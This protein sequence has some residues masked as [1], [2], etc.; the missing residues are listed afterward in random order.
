MD[1]PGHHHLHQASSPLSLAFDATS[2]SPS[3]RP[4]LGATGGVFSIYLSTLLMADDILFQRDRLT[5]AKSHLT[6]GR[7][8]A[9]YS[10]ISAVSIYDGRPL[11]ASAIMS[12]VG[13]LPLGL[14]FFS[15]ARLF[16]AYFPVKM[17]VL[18]SLPLIMFIVFGFVYRV[19]CLFVT[20]DGQ[21][22]A[23]LKSK[24]ISVLEEAKARIEEAKTSIRGRSV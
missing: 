23:V 22:I 15:G 18:M 1:Q 3:L 20:I 4:S 2:R 8:T 12:S 13:L 14:L 5:V 17:I 24:D 19:K 7:V 6:V 16:G 9:F 21:S 11:L 10:N